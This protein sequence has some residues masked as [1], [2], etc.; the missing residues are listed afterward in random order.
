MPD[1]VPEVEHEGPG[2]EELEAAL[3]GDGPGSDGGCDA[4]A[5]QVPARQGRDEVGRREDVYPSREDGARDALPG[6]GAEPR[7]VL[8]VYL[9]VRAHGS[10]QALPREERLFVCV[11]ALLCLGGR[12]GSGDKG[13]AGC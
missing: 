7:L 13:E 3:D 2:D 9:E 1:A 10:A 12:G 8:A 4:R 11:R 5:L 6:R